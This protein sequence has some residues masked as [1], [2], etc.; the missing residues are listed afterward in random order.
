MSISR[1]PRQSDRQRTE[2]DA[3]GRWQ[4]TGTIFVPHRQEIDSHQFEIEIKGE[5]FEIIQTGDTYTIADPVTAEL[6]GGNWI[7][8][9]TR[10]DYH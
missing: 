2:P 4:F 8:W 9:W 7:G 3:S 6:Y 10:L 5:T 1:T